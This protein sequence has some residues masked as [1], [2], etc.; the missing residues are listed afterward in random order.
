MSSNVCHFRSLNQKFQYYKTETPHNAYLKIGLQEFSSR[1]KQRS[2]YTAAIHELFTYPYFSLCI[3]NIFHTYATS[4]L[5]IIWY[6]DGKIIKQSHKVRI[7]IKDNKTSVTIKKCEP[8][9]GGLYLCKAIS[10]IGEAVTRAKLSVKSIQFFSQ[11][12]TL[13]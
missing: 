6:H 3:C 11:L 1:K 2:L 4:I 13:R 5:D 12:N 7:K 10:R 8:D 9:D